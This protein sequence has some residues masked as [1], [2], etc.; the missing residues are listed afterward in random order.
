MA[1]AG[2]QDPGLTAAERSARVAAAKMQAAYNLM[3]VINSHFGFMNSNRP[4]ACFADAYAAD[5]KVGNAI[6]A[7]A[8][9]MLDN[10]GSGD[11]AGTQ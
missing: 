2:F 9:Y 5:I 7:A 11:L 3:L 4:A 1:V 10:Q 6:W 8:K